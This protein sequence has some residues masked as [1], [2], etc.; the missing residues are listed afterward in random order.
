MKTCPAKSPRSPR[1]NPVQGAG[2]AGTEPPEGGRWSGKRSRRI[3]PFWFVSLAVA[4]ALLTTSCSRLGRD[5][6]GSPAP[7]KSPRN[8]RPKGAGTKGS[9]AARAQAN[10]PK[11]RLTV[12]AAYATSIEEPWDGVIHQALRP[13]G[14][15]EAEGRITYTWKDAI[16]YRGDMPA[17][18][19]SLHDIAVWHMQPTVN[20]VLTQV[21][22]G[23]FTAQDL[24]DFSSMVK[25]GASLIPYH[26]F[27]DTLRV[28]ASVKEL[29]ATRQREIVS[30]LFRVNI[31]E[32]APRPAGD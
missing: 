22:A 4:S 9:G 7:A 25:G 5:P 12:F 1:P 21:A 11:P 24:K 28:P 14:S 6:A 10:N 26:N 8:P 30:G 2:G 15:A 3:R 23:V 29:I 17:Q 16:G 27:D 32:D 20:Y 13:I 31:A 19:D 18:C